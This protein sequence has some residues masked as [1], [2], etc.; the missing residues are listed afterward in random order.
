MPGAS[1]W[2]IKDNILERTILCSQKSRRF[3]SIANST[4]IYASNFITPS[5]SVR[6][7]T[8]KIQFFLDIPEVVSLSHSLDLHISLDNRRSDDGSKYREA[9]KG[10]KGTGHPKI[11]DAAVNKAA[12]ERMISLTRRRRLKN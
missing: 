9:S 6:V 1:H 10:K 5:I 2:E 3:T 12:E 11:Q 4:F 8:F 7:D